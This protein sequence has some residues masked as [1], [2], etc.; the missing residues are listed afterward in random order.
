M[1]KL[2]AIILAFLIITSGC[3]VSSAE[4][5][6]TLTSGEWEYVLYEGMAKITKYTGTDGSD[7]PVTIPGE[8][9]G[10]MVTGIEVGTFKNSIGITGIEIPE[11]VSLAGNP[12]G[13]CM[14][15]REIKVS[16][17][18]QVLEVVD[19]VLFGNYGGIRFLI[20]R[21]A[22]LPGETYEIP[23]GVEV[24]AQYAF[25][26]C[27][28]LTGITIPSSVR[29]IGND[30]FYGCMELENIEIPDSVTRIGANAFSSCKALRTIS[31][32]DSVTEIG[33]NPFTMCDCLQEIIVSENH[34]YL[35]SI[36]GVLFSRPWSIL[37]C[38]PKYFHEESYVV[39]DGIWAI[40]GRAFS[41]C[42]SLHSVI[43][44]SGLHAI[45]DRAFLLCSSLTEIEIPDG[46]TEIGPQ[47]FALCGALTRITIPA[48]VTEIGE[49][50][51]FN[52]KNLTAVV[53]RD[54]YAAAYCEEHSIPVEYTD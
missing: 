24:I 18:N 5:Q 52:C 23:A 10:H 20:C 26:W 11:R 28:T 1:R 45:F 31:I 40:G 21:P 49:D 34:P 16:P 27:K 13:D 41:N 39:P 14:Q 6:E 29:E 48:S 37:V 53:T 15:L 50:A 32:P 9:D 51:F 22:A 54:S 42:T 33:D 47:A 44:P 19:G 17:D 46:V 4:G 7:R 25:S 43:L 2:A 36:D 3:A 12:F 8:L 30:A 38:Y 35:A